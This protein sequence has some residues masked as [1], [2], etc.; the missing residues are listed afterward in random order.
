ME[1]AK[2]VLQILVSNPGGHFEHRL[3]ILL[4]E[5]EL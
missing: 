4:F 5:I 2:V 3:V 1:G